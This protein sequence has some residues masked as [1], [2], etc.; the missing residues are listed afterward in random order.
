MD[1]P[2]HI[3]AGALI[4]NGMAYIATRS[5]RPAMTRQAWIKTGCAAFLLGVC[6]HLLLDSLPYFDWLFYIPLFKPLPS[7]WL[8]PPILTAI[9]VVAAAL[10]WMWDV[11]EL[12]AAAMIGGAYPDIEKLLFFD[13][14][15]PASLLLFKNHSRTLSGSA[16]ERAHRPLLIVF[17]IVVFALIMVGMRWINRRRQRIS[18]A[19]DVTPVMFCEGE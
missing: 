1:L 9:P 15:L 7:W 18:R 3:A 8:Y 6:A 11:R 10:Y 5:P 12:A 17:E 2:V 13:W 19:A 16:W 14:G 4:G